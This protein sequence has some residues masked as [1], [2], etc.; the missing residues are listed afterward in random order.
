[1]GR[2]PAKFRAIR[3]QVI[4]NRLP[5]AEER[6]AIAFQDPRCGSKGQI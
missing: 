1:M 2:Q 4:H 5:H 6:V 3:D